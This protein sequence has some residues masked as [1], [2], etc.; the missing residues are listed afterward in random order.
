MKRFKLFEQFIGKIPDQG[1]KGIDQVDWSKQNYVVIKP[2]TIRDDGEDLTLL[3]VGDL[4][5]RFKYEPEE[6][7][8]MTLL[9]SMPGQE[10]DFGE[11]LEY[12]QKL[13]SKEEYVKFL[14]THRGAISGSKFK[15]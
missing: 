3:A 11:S 13:N 10:L 5:Q 4:V 15:F 12:L 14:Q 8:I 2:L 6:Q 9:G 7:M 1:A